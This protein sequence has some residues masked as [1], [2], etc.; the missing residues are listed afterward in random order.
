MKVRKGEGL[1]SPE[2]PALKEADS[3]KTSIDQ[4]LVNAR[5]DGWAHV[6]A[7]GVQSHLRPAESNRL[8]ARDAGYAL[9]VPW[10]RLGGPEGE[11]GSSEGR[12]VVGHSTFRGT[13]LVTGCGRCGK[14]ASDV[15]C[16]AAALSQ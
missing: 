2:T 11:D 12:R 16:S 1:S 3:Q 6:M 7:L 10:E 13:G 8:R 15:D 14:G 4:T 9:G 5:R